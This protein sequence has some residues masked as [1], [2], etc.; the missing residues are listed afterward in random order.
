MEMRYYDLL[1]TTIIGVIVVSI[2]NY[3]FCGNVEIDTVVYVA[4]GYFSGYFINALGSL[5]EDMYY[6]TIGGKPSDKLLTLVKGQ[7]WTG[8]N[9]IKFYETEKVVEFLKNELQDQNASV[10][11]CLNVLREKRMVVRI[12]EC[13]YLVL[14]MRGREQYLQQY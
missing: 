6:K 2:V 14:N 5:F 3:F 7:D 8:C 9:R 12:V 4:L 11:K 13:M 10:K 1:S